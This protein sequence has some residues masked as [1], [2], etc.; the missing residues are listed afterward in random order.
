MKNTPRLVQKRLFIVLASVVILVVGTC[1]YLSFDGTTTV[2]ELYYAHKARTVLAQENLLL[3]NP[4]RKLGFTSITRGDNENCIDY[5]TFIVSS[6]PG[7]PVDKIQC[8]A[9]IKSYK[10]FDNEN[11]VNKAV[12]A[13]QEIS[14][15]MEQN[16]WKRGNYELGTW[17]K[18]VL[19]K[20][21]Y[22]PDAY[23]YKYV[24]DKFCVIDFFVAYSNPKPPAVQAIFTC[25]TPENN[26]PL[27]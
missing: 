22:S 9:E 3:K 7:G 16:G 27:I 8:S 17:F 10:V 2:K 6:L 23:H 15:L 21:D 26:P 20:A 4:L 24:D 13:A 12:E 1:A 11:D 25:T 5:S 19:N 18:G 14:L